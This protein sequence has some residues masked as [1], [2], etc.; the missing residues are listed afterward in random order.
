MEK[1]NMLTDD[2][3]VMMY[4]NGNNEAFDI[5]LDRYKSKL[6]SYIY[7]T[8]HDE[9]LA[10]D[11]FQETF[12]KV[13]TRIQAHRYT[14]SGKFQAWL[15]RIAHNLIIDYYRQKNNENSVSKDEVEY[16]VFNDMTS[17]DFSYES[18]LVNEQ[19]LSDVKTLC[20]LLPENQSQVV[21]MRYYS[22]MSFKEIADTL[23]IS[24]NTALGRMRY[25]LINMRRMVSEK[26]ISLTLNDLC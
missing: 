12:V 25:A 19:T 7:Y 4:A 15:T 20:S 1:G 5:L 24:I 16:D 26:N 11:I 21:Y 17:A 9:S 10:D 2:E 18:Q 23:D 8:V 22:N 6:F 14:A 3:L 13:I